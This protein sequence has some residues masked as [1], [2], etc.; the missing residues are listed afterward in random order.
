MKKKWLIPLAGSVLSGLLL[1]GCTNNKNDLNP[2]PPT[3]KNQGDR[4]DNHNRNNNLTPNDTNNDVTPN[5]QNDVINNDDHYSPAE[6]KNT[7]SDKD[8]MKDSNTKREE[9]IEDDIDRNDRD[10]KDE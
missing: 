6:D 1:V 8:P 4:D 3:V 2:P 5:D 9:I 7:D 10:N